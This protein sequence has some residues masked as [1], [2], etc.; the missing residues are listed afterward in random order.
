MRLTAA[1]V[2]LV[3][4]GVIYL[5]SILFAKKALGGYEN[6][7]IYIVTALIVIC[8]MLEAVLKK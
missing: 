6:E 7:T 5:L 8:L 3:I 2:R 4:I 1:E